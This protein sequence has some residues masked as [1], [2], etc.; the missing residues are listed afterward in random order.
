MFNGHSLDLIHIVKH[1]T[2]IYFS[3]PQIPPP[4]PD[5]VPLMTE[6]H[7][8]LTPTRDGFGNAFY[9][10]NNQRDLYENGNIMNNVGNGDARHLHEGN[11]DN[12]GANHL[13]VNGIADRAQGLEV[14]NGSL[15]NGNVPN[16]VQKNNV[17]VEQRSNESQGEQLETEMKTKESDKMNERKTGKVDLSPASNNFDTNK[18]R[19]DLEEVSTTGSP[20]GAC[21][22]EILKL[23]DVDNKA[24]YKGNE[25]KDMMPGN[26]KISIR[27]NQF[28]NCKILIGGMKGNI[29]RNAEPL[30]SI[31]GSFDNNSSLKSE[32][33]FVTNSVETFKQ[34]GR[35]N[36]NQVTEKV[37]EEDC[38]NEGQKAPFCR[39]ELSNLGFGTQGK[40]I[41]S[42]QKD[43][44]EGY[45]EGE[46]DLEQVDPKQ[47]QHTKKFLTERS[48]SSP[49]LQDSV[50]KGKS[51]VCLVS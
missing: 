7:V 39:P 30:T 46:M 51:I 29:I 17:D 1:F 12:I 9:M 43:C 34:P 3:G 41:Q 25:L 21:G 28:K 8:V 11:I 33:S 44:V 47:K 18:E 42:R 45:D 10:P 16:S 35:R 49:P 23:D 6:G 37:D 19:H 14:S 5:N 24:G 4:T 36:G 32:D 2:G 50:S 20:E 27:G 13:H 48:M 31:S 38:E 22:S 15:P 26:N 40:D